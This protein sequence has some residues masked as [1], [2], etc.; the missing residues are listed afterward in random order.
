M[1]ISKQVSSYQKEAPFLISA[2]YKKVFQELSN[3]R[4]EQQPHSRPKLTAKRYKYL[5]ALY[6]IIAFGSEAIAKNLTTSNPFTILLDFISRFQWHSLAL[7]E[8]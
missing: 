6:F 1:V 8:I 5:Q 4:T 3:A 7:V 2:L